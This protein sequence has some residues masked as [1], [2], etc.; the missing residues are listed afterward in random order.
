[1]VQSSFLT[2]VIKYL[3]GKIKRQEVYF[4]SWFSEVQSTRARRISQLFVYNEVAGHCG[5]YFSHL[6][7]VWNRNITEL[8]LSYIFFFKLIILFTL[9]PDYNFSSPPHSASFSPPFI[10][11]SQS[12][13]LPQRRGGLPWISLCLG[14]SSC[15]R[16]RCIISSIVARQGMGYISKCLSWMAHLFHP[17]PLSS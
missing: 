14:I 8:W 12:S 7:R 17:G 2:T 16:A 1:M 6:R 15:S 4:G 9:H 10:P 3:T 5:F 13:L 11:I